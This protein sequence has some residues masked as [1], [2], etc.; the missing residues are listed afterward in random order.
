M[1]NLPSESKS[2]QKR[3]KRGNME[4]KEQEYLDKIA[5][6]DNQLCSAWN[7]IDALRNQIKALQEINDAQWANIERHRK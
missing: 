7:M 2:P 6:L 1:V 5:D 4:G 3:L